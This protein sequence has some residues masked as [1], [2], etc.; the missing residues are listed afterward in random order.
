MFSI[1]RFFRPRQTQPCIRERTLIEALMQSELEAE[2]CRRAWSANRERP[3]SSKE[4]KREDG[5]PVDEPRRI[6]KMQVSTLDQEEASIVDIG[7]D[8][9]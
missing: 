1:K 7:L 5:L 2:A 4:V 6:S 3:D 8:T 9:D